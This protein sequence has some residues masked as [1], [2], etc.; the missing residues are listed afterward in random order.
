MN[1]PA[2]LSK[3][4]KGS[5]EP[6]GAQFTGDKGINILA[7]GFSERSSQGQEIKKSPN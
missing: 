6:L 2:F 7:A 4:A 5:T 3:H 1:T